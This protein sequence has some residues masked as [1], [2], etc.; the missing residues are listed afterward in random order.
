MLI[1]RNQSLL[2]VV[3]IQEKLAPAIHDGADA[4][5]NNRKRAR[6]DGCW[7]NKYRAIADNRKRPGSHCRCWREH[8]TIADN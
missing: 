1:D 5:A 8:L 6:A 4:I 2:L 7:R 3:D